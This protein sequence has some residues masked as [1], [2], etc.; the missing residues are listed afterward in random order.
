MIGF[1][2]LKQLLCTFC[3]DWLR[4]QLGQLVHWS[5]KFKFSRKKVSGTWIDE[6]VGLPDG[7]VSHTG[8]V[9]NFCRGKKKGQ[10]LDYDRTQSSVLS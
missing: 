1:R 4:L 5:V 8:N 2:I 9:S 6:P 3:A 7:D 10:Q